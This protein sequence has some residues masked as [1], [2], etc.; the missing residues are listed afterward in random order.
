MDNKDLDVS[1]L[2][3]LERFI[4]GNCLSLIKIKEAVEFYTIL[5]GLLPEN[6]IVSQSQFNTYI[7]Q[8]RDFARIMGF[9]SNKKIEPTFNGIKI[10]VK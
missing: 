3:I 8:L 10:I 6:I 5:N 4:D 9:D 2:N 7:D 1:N